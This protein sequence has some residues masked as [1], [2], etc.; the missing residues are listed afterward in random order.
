[1]TVSIAH[2]KL[3]PDQAQVLLQQMAGAPGSVKRML[4][5][6]TGSGPEA[7]LSPHQR[8]TGEAA[9]QR[10]TLTGNAVA[11]AVNQ[12][13]PALGASVKSFGLARAAQVPS[14]QIEI[15]ADHHWEQ[16][17][18]NDQTVALD[19]TVRNAAVDQKLTEATD[20]FDPDALA[21]PLFQRVRF[22]V[23]GDFL[24]ERPP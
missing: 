4:G 2:G 24:G 17:T 12:Q 14:R 1:V 7:E 9:A 20:T 19:P 18:I 6:L 23:V 10:A 13:Y 5:A 22:R 8:E 16:A 21:D 3:S 15:V 11:D